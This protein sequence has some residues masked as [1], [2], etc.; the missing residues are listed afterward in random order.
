MLCNDRFRFLNRQET[1]DSAGC[2]NPNDLPK[3]WLYNLHYFDGLM[4]PE[5][6]TSVKCEV[7]SS[8]I[9]GNPPAFGNGWEAYPLSLRIVNWIKWSLTGHPLGEKA[10]HSLAVQTRYLMRTIEYHLLGN[11]LFANA[12]ALVFAGCF[13]KGAE[14]TRWC[15]KGMEILQKQVPEQFLAD[16]AH[17]EL[18]PTYHA[19][20]TEDLLD[21][22]Q[23]LRLAGHDVPADWPGFI[24][25]AL[26]W[27][28]VMTRP[29]GFPP[30]FNDA[31]YGVA[32]ASKDVW[33]YAARLG[34]SQPDA[35][36]PGLTDLA[37][38]GYFRFEAPGY[39]FIG[40]AGQI[41]PDYIPGHGH[42][43]MLSFELFAGGRPVIVDTGTSTYEIGGRRL[44]ERGTA[45]H[46]TVQIDD[47]EQ[48]QIWSGFRVG[49]RARIVER[50]VA[51][52]SIRAAH[53]GFRDAGIIHSRRFDFA[54]ERITLEDR[55]SG[56]R[57]NSCKAVAR[58]HFHPDVEPNV[59]NGQ[60]TAGPIS[61][62]F[63]GAD[64][65]DK[66]PY[67]YAP[68]FN[69]LLPAYTLAVAFT[70]RLKTVLSL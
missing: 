58:F 56:D 65:I 8:W 32:P 69:R 33:S 51:G 1:L 7:I 30:L 6:D 36:R 18:S 68:E 48:S 47:R 25:A 5:T 4:N 42:C 22:V 63:E 28:K 3:L 62:R 39:A 53:D 44:L 45:A 38:S 27:L 12:K 20:L 10:R 60:I 21:V 64:S 31:A 41:G 14:A 70:G 55:L 23:I 16:G 43:D 17:F 54:A 24:R 66:D 9:D 11:H 59:Q 19:L 13:F 57:A 26:R 2:W 52:S 46:N 67:L 50:E 35:A 37:A 49:R 34:F 61:L 40:D 29:D 15:A